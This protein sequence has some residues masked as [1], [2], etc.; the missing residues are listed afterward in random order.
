VILDR[1]C[2]RCSGETDSCH[3]M[4]RIEGGLTVGRG[5]II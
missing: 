5:P 4:Y 1:C 3:V 2:V